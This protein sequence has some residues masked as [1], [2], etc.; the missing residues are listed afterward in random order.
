MHL[1][2]T[3]GHGRRPSGHGRGVGS[4]PGQKEDPN[5]TAKRL[6]QRLGP[7]MFRVHTANTRLP[8]PEYDPS[9]R[10]LR[11]STKSTL[12][13][14]RR[15][16]RAAAIRTSSAVGNGASHAMLKL[17]QLTESPAKRTPQPEGAAGAGEDGGGGTVEPV[18]TVPSASMVIWMVT[19]PSL[20]F[21]LTRNPCFPEFRIVTE[22]VPTS[23]IPDHRGEETDR[24]VP[25]PCTWR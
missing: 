10:P 19:S 5:D 20:V 16:P 15:S 8:S 21:W 9:M 17:P 6:L 4:G 22:L 25:S 3:D 18:C 2:G 13:L 1:N 12:M 24:R 14:R 7:L 23:S 11:R